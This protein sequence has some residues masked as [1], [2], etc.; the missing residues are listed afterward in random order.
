M[1]RAPTRIIQAGER[2][3]RGLRRD[4]AAAYLGISTGKFD[5]WVARKLM[6]APKRQDGV[7]VWDRLSLDQAFES[8]PDGGAT[9]ID[10][11]AD[12]GGNQIAAR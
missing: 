12:L 7:V 10:T 2:W 6:P 11:W 8:L 5:D 3:P 1:S 9:D 4:D